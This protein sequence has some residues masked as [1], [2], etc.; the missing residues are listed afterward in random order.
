MN[1]EFNAFQGVKDQNVIN[2]INR[3]F[4]HK[5][6]IGTVICKID[7]TLKS[8]NKIKIQELLKKY[9]EEWRNHVGMTQEVVKY[10]DVSQYQSNIEVLKVMI[11][12][13][14]STCRDTCR[15]GR[16]GSLLSSTQFAQNFQGTSGFASHETQEYHDF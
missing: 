5:R 13:N 12:H 2:L 1:I 4:N 16:E 10:S 14:I 11:K 8:K 9:L 15:M 6:M 3:A 7:S